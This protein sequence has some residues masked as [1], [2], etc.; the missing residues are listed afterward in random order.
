MWPV[1]IKVSEQFQLFCYAAGFDGILYLQLLQDG[2]PVPADCVYA[3]AEHSGNR[4]AR[5]AFINKVQD[6]FFPIG[7]YSCIVLLL[8]FPHLT[9]G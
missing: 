6:L 8:Q 1:R 2:L 3:D 4:L 5:Q 7:Q 9:V